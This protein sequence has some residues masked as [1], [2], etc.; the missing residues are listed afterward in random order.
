MIAIN[1][2]RKTVYF[3]AKLKP[4]TAYS[5]IKQ[6]WKDSDI[7]VRYPFPVRWVGEG[8]NTRFVTDGDTWTTNISDL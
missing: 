1:L 4:K 7:L 5:K 8:V 6:M 2:H 3:S